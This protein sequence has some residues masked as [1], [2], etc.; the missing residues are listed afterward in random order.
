M[1]SLT[2]SFGTSLVCRSVSYGTSRPSYGARGRFGCSTS[3]YSLVISG[4]SC[5]ADE[6][7]SYGTIPLSLGTSTLSYGTNGPGLGTYPSLPRV[8]V[9]VVPGRTPLAVHLEVAAVA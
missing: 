2:N 6:V 5:G 3:V 8:L 1:K 9:E 4:L 7:G